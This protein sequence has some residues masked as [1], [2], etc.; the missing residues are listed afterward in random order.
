MVT[1]NGAEDPVGGCLAYVERFGH[2]AKLLPYPGR[3]RSRHPERPA[4]P[5]LVEPEQSTGRRC[6]AERSSRAGDVP[7]SVVVLR[8][9]R[10]PYSTLNLES[11]GEGHDEVPAAGRP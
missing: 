6:G 5:P 10:E 9:D 8:V 1:E 4:H 7:A 2:R 11:N 3:L